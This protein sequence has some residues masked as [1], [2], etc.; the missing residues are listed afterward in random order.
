LHSS[1]GEPRGKA[2]SLWLL[3]SV[4][5]L[6]L[7]FKTAEQYISE[8]LEIRQ[9]IG[10]R[11]TD[12]S[13]ELQD[14]GMTLTWLG[15]LDEALDVRMETLNIYQDR[16]L[17]EKIPN[18]FIRLAFSQMHS[19]YVDDARES[20]TLAQTLAE[21]IDDPRVIGLAS[22]VLGF[23]EMT[24]GNIE[25]ANLF[26]DQSVNILQKVKGAGELGWALSAL[27]LTKYQ[28][29]QPQ[30]FCECLIQAFDIGKG[31]LGAATSWI[32]ISSYIFCLVERDEIELAVELYALIT[33]YPLV[34]Q[35]HALYFSSGQYVDEAS[36]TLPAEIVAEAR[37]R[38]RN[39][40]LYETIAEIKS[41]LEREIE[42]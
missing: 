37:E 4:E 34:G 6:K 32:A 13:S 21:E 39:R 20:A 25:G 3:G 11:I 9:R 31:F 10:E 16:G 36:E 1:S 26:G 23:Y 29:K 41:K 40:D 2:D 14:I 12:I 7:E 19:G 17:T 5:I 24:Q 30:E 35:S 15:K 27:A 28:L 8:S 42:G 33:Q 22:I 38:G 18:A